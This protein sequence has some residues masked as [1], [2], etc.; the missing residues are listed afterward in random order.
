MRLLCVVQLKAGGRFVRLE[1]AF[2]FA[3]VDHL[4]SSPTRAGGWDLV[5]QQPAH[6]VA[7][8][9]HAFRLSWQYPS[10]GRIGGGKPS[11]LP[12]TETRAGMLH[13]TYQSVHA[14]CFSNSGILMHLGAS[15]NCI[16]RWMYG[17]K[18]GQSCKFARLWQVNAPTHERRNL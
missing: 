5:P 7:P 1:H 16:Q 14:L 18:A 2:P 15:V 6:K 9:V 17:E 13:L 4:F 10:I 3:Q 12:P 8:R 11:P